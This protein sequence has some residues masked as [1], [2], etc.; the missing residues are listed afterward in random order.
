M[1]EE[2]LERP[3]E[4]EESVINEKKTVGDYLFSWKRKYDNFWYHYKLALI[5]GVII[6][7][8]IIFCIAQCSGRKQGDANVAY[9]GSTEINIEH[10]EN[11]QR[12]LNELLGEDLNGD[13]EI[14][15]DFTHFLYMTQSQIESARAEGKPVD[16]QA[17][18]TV[19]TQ[20]NLEFAAGNIVIFFID[21]AVYREFSGRAGLFMPLEDSLGYLP[22]NA[23][24]A[25]TLKLG[26]LAC[27]DYYE[28]LNDF[29]AGTVIAV[30]N[31]M[32]EEESK[33]DVR[34][35][36]ERNM[37]LLKRMVDFTYKQ[38]DLIDQTDPEE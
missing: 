2:N 31:I 7:A 20:V 1:D 28:G 38:D 16:M 8:F 12:A 21:P 3:E 33:K 23:H 36:Y 11:L 25:Y 4:G 27:W 24:D 30:K 26:N 5:F 34:E 37:K 6:L 10:F 17:M 13:G 18:M 35:L 22:D 29:P 14:H 9:I 19:Q 15:V 32:L